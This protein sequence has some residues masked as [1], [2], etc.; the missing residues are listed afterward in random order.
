MYLFRKMTK[1]I[2]KSIEFEQIQEDGVRVKM[3]EM[4]I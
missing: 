4:R 2:S 3:F 1:L